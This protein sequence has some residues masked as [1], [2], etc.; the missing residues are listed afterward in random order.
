MRDQ[1]G[2]YAADFEHCKLPMALLECVTLNINNK[3]VFT[4]I[5]GQLTPFL[6]TS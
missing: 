5:R 4:N 2:D 3:A 6:V 1:R